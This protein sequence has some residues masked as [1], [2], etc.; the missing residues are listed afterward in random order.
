MICQILTRERSCWDD[1]TIQKLFKKKFIYAAD[2]IVQ[3][4][5]TP[6]NVMKSCQL[7]SSNALLRTTISVPEDKNTAYS[8]FRSADNDLWDDTTRSGGEGHPVGARRRDAA[9]AHEEVWGNDVYIAH[10]E[11]DEARERG[12]YR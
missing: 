5:L 9:I 11:E 2:L 8:K 6:R 12:G 7:L 3:Y 1:D 4:I 10:K